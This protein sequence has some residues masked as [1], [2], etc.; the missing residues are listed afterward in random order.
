MT[1]CAGGGYMSSQTNGVSQLGPASLSE[2]LH[3]SADNDP[4]DP[5]PA[6]LLRKFVAYASKFVKPRLSAE[7]KTMLGA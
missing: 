1:Y 2:R 4:T 7:A 5:I 6:N 3:L